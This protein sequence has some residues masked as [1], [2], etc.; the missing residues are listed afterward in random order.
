VGNG[1]NITWKNTQLNLRPDGSIW[2]PEWSTWVLSDVHF[3]KITHFRKHGISLPSKAMHANRQRIEKGMKLMNPGRV[4][5]TGD[6]FHSTA[7]SEMSIVRELIRD[8]PKTEFILTAGNHDRFTTHEIEKLGIEV[9]ETYTIESCRFEHEK[10]EFS[11]SVSGHIHPVVMLSGK[12]RQKL[13]LKSFIVHSDYI[14]LPAFGSFTGGHPYELSTDEHAYLL[15]EN[16][17]FAHPANPSVSD[18]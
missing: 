14:V 17:V 16:H 3:G 1:I 6:L 4:I 15:G 7:N 2:I 12:G 8:Y 10:S 9:V 13:R 5:F 11:G 18:S